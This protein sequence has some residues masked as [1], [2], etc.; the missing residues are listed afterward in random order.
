MNNNLDKVKLSLLKRRRSEGL[1]K[2]YG[3]AGIICA[4]SFLIII[5]YS[6]I[7]QGQKAFFTSYIKLDVYFDSKIIDPDNKKKEEDIKF[8]NFRKIITTSL[9]RKFPQVSDKEDI[10]ELASFISSS[11]EVLIPVDNINGFCVL[12]SLSIRGRFVKSAE[13][14]LYASTPKDSRTSTLFLSQGVHI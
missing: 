4:V 10:K 11:E 9:E 5:L 12:E 13:A 14:T 7:S 3:F 6:V 2:F 8:A 1:F